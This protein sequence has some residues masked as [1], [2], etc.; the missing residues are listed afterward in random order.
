MKIALTGHT[1]G[2]GKAILDKLA[3]NNDVCGFSRSNGFDISIED[4]REQIWQACKDYDVFINNAWHETG[5]EDLL[6][7]FIVGWEGKNKTIINIGSVIT[8]M[9]NSGIMKRA[10]I[11]TY[12]DSKHRLN[13]ICD[14]RIFISYPRVVNIL[15]DKIG[16]KKLSLLEV[17]DCVYYMLYTTKNLRNI[18]IVK[19]NGA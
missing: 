19:T 10:Y 9:M 7:R 1:K 15:V 3:Q 2:I 14:S 12:A 17:A 8:Y 13:M 16:D 18:T 5:Q 4:H 11:K 6:N